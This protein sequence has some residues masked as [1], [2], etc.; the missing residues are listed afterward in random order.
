[1]VARGI[2]GLPSGSVGTLI[3]A[4]IK[5]QVMLVR[6]DKLV[7]H[8]D[9]WLNAFKQTAWLASIASDVDWTQSLIKIMSCSF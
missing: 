7:M 3:T 9:I 8:S 5:A 1:M 2:S 6:S 4:L